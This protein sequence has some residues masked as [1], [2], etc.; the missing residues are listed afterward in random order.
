MP[1]KALHHLDLAVTD[2]E[3]SLQFYLALLG[4]LG[5]EELYRFPTYRGTE[6]VVYVGVGPGKQ[7]IGFRR[8][9]GG[10]HRYYDVGVEH[11]ALSVDSREEVEAV[12]DRA[13]EMGARIHFPVEEDRDIPGYW[14][15]FI[16]DPDGL[17]LEVF[18]WPGEDEWQQ[19]AEESAS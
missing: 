14:A 5:V 15:V 2:P 8:A 12:Y 9:D 16:F 13:V 1:V 3:R 4:P 10:E 19:G 11:I 17:R 18:C 7:A 6:E